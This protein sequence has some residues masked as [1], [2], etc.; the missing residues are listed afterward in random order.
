M[1]DMIYDKAVVGYCFT[2][3]EFGIPWIERSDIEDRGEGI[4]VLR[5]RCP[6]DRVSDAYFGIMA[7]AVC[8]EM[9]CALHFVHMTKT[10]YGLPFEDCVWIL[11]ENELDINEHDAVKEMCPDRVAESR[12]GGQEDK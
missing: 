5:F 8:S 11:Q 2:D 7:D 10:E 9:N 6:P 3:N 12:D 1:Y 4:F